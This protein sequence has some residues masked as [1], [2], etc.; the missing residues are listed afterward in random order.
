[1]VT[2]ASGPGRSRRRTIASSSASPS[3]AVSR[4]CAR[5]YEL[6]LYALLDCEAVAGS[7]RG[8]TLRRDNEGIFSDDTVY[9]K[10]DPQHDRRSGY[11]FG[12]NAEGAQIDAL[13]LEDG[14]EYVTQ[15]DGVW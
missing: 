15:W 14:R 13:G 12:V 8:R 9:V 4:R 3:S 7:T 5:R 6:A 1:M 11:S 10:L 2:R